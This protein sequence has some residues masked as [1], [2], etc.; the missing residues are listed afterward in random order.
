MLLYIDNALNPNPPRILL[1][2][3]KTTVNPILNTKPSLI[4][5]I[6]PAKVIT[7][8]MRPFHSTGNIAYEYTESK[9]TDN[10]YEP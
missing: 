2:N 1:L 4:S 8:L 7:I 6:L 10:R 5:L 9:Y 3:P